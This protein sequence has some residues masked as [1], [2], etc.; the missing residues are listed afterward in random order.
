MHLTYQIYLTWPLYRLNEALKIQRMACKCLLRTIQFPLE[1]ACFYETASYSLLVLSFYFA[2]IKEP[3][4]L[5][6]EKGS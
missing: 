5:L 6:L 3:R 2:K 4:G 1:Y